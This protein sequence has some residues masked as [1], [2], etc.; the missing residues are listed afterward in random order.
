MAFLTTTPV[1]ILTILGFDYKYTKILDL[2][3]FLPALVCLVVIGY[4]YIMVNLSVRCNQGVNGV[5]ASSGRAK[6]KMATSIANKTAILALALLISY[7]P[8]IAVLFLGERVPFPRTSSFFR[9][10]E[11]LTQLNSLV[12]PL[13]YCFAL[14]GNFRQEVLKVLK[15][16]RSEEIQSP[17]RVQRSRARPVSITPEGVHDA[18]EFEEREQED[19]FEM[20]G[21]RGFVTCS[22]ADYWTPREPAV[23]ESSSSS[24]VVNH[25]IWSV[26]VY[27]PK[28]IKCKPNTRASS[29]AMNREDQAQGTSDQCRC[30]LH[31]HRDQS[32]DEND[33]M[34]IKLD[35]KTTQKPETLAPSPYSEKPKSVRFQQKLEATSGVINRRDQAE[36]TSDQMQCSLYH[37]HQEYYNENAVVEL[38][39]GQNKTPQRSKKTA[40][41]PEEIGLIL[42]F[43]ELQQ[44]CKDRPTR[45]KPL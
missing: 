29:S 31:Y 28:P 1:R 32:C 41:S 11:V 44:R 34:D 13:L 45:E 35:G 30:F 33:V 3:F 8:L 9:W 40:P 12:N 39:S 37:V 36:G 43:P 4:F 25:I 14:N 42:S 2:I 7:V 5:R 16:G 18:R 20:P 19:C 24:A 17:T 15:M 27:Q 6:A 22:D 21:S 38:A 26:D 23:E 10:S